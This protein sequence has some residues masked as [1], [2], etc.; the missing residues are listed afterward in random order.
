MAEAQEATVLTLS[1]VEQMLSDPTFGVVDAN[2]V[3]VWSDIARDKVTKALKQG[4]NGAYNKFLP[5]EFAFQV[6]DETAER[7][8]YVTKKFEVHTSATKDRRSMVVLLRES[9]PDHAR[10]ISVVRKLESAFDTSA[11][12]ELGKK[13]NR[14]DSCLWEDTDEKSERYGQ[15]TGLK[16]KYDAERIGNV[17]V[18]VRNQ[19]RHVTSWERCTYDDIPQR[20]KVWFSVRVHMGCVSQ[21]KGYVP[22]EIVDMFAESKPARKHFAGNMMTASGRSMADMVG[23]GKADMDTLVDDDD[24]LAGTKRGRDDDDADPAS[25]RTRDPGFADDRAPTN[26]DF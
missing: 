25:P 18:A 8:M 16:V 1:D 5:T 21:E 14:L 15:V 19:D 11:R 7:W 26:D 4:N 12:A 10:L 13:Y 24:T 6:C 9:D 2:G 23:T 20:S 17:G 3:P 22:F